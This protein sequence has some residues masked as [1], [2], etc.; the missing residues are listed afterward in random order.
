MKGRSLYLFDLANQDPSTNVLPQSIR[1]YDENS[2]WECKSRYAKNGTG[3]IATIGDI[4][5]FRGYYMT[6]GLHKATA[7]NSFRPE[8][9]Y[10]D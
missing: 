7:K 1:S 3:E 2:A 6:D 5:N 9:L 4:E 10:M 8:Y